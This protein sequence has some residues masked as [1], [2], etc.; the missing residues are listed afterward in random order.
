LEANQNG[1]AR[2]RKTLTMS[3]LVSVPLTLTGCGEAV[4]EDW[5]AYEECQYEMELTGV[6]LDCEDDDSDWYKK[7]GYYKSKKV[8]SS[9]YKSSGSG[10]GSGYS[11]GG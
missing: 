11:S 2:L 3:L 7:K 10:Y 9:Y 4:Q 8:K 6:Q 5:T 1:K